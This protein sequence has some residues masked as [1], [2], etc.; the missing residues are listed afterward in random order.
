MKDFWIGFTIIFCAVAS[1]FLIDASRSE[2]KPKFE[3]NDCFIDKEAES[4]E[5]KIFLVLDVGKY[6]YLYGWFSP[7]GIFMKADWRIEWID[8]DNV[9]AECT[10]A[11]KRIING[12]VD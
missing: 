2:K 4:W 6:K 8:K 12:T 1:Y 10:P 11:L 3:I 9:K 5:E 7:S